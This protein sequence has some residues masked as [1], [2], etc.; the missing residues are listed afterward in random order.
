[1]PFSKSLDPGGVSEMSWADA[2]WAR[3]RT[4]SKL[5][6][7]SLETVPCMPQCL[8]MIKLCR[9][10]RFYVLEL[11]YKSTVYLIICYHTLSIPFYF[12]PFTSFCVS[13]WVKRDLQV[14]SL[15]YFS[16]GP[17][18]VLKFKQ[19][20]FSCTLFFSFFWPNKLVNML[21]MLCVTP[22]VSLQMQLCSPLAIKIPFNEETNGNPSKVT[23][24][25]KNLM[26]VVTSYKLESNISVPTC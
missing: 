11:Q 9:T 26:L 1:M 24:T 14:W 18:Y 2:E 4:C 19:E 10:L 15:E 6:D 22:V 23:W 17:T 12:F 7:F 5:H 13:K 20:I 25:A 3:A 8:H 16:H 21:F